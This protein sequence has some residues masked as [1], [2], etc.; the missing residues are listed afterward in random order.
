MLVVQFVIELVGS[1]APLVSPRSAEGEDEAPLEAYEEGALVQQREAE[2]LLAGPG[3][4]AR[5]L[6]WFLQF[7]PEDQC[8]EVV[9]STGNVPEDR[10]Q[11]G[12]E[13]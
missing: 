2:K 6:C 5:Q 3:R 13:I 8:R 4:N 9:D 11:S 1:R 7:G 10:E 12:A